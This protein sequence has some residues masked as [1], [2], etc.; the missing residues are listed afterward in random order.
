[1]RALDCESGR[2]LEAAHDEELFE[3]ARE[4]VD[5]T[6]LTGASATSRFALSSSRA[7]TTSRLPKSQVGVLGNQASPRLREATADDTPGLGR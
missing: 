4:H 6:T 1:M 5:R 2:H 3:R 7:P